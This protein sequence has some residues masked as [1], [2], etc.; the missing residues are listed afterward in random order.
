MTA[1]ASDDDPLAWTL[2]EAAEAVRRGAISSEALTGLCLERIDRLQPSLN[3][4][5]GV[6]G[7]RA[8][9]AARAADA[10]LASGAEIG[11]LHGVPLAHKDMFYRA[12]AVTTGGSR[13]WR[14]RVREHT[15]EVL[16]RLDT[17]GAIELG[18]LNLSEFA[19][20]PTGQNAHHGRACN[21]WDPALI[22]GGS[23]SGSAAAVAAG[24]AFGALGSDT[25]GSIRLP[26]AL[27]GVAGLKP[28][29][30]RVSVRD[31][32]PLA[33][34]MDCV[35][36]LARSVADLALI[37]AV[38]T[39]ASAE[40]PPDPAWAA[41]ALADRPSLQGVRIGIP[42]GLD[43]E[44]LEAEVAASLAKSR[45]DLER[46]GARLVTIAMPD[47]DTLCDLAGVVSMYEAAET[48]ADDFAA[49][50]EDYGPQ[51]RSRL[52]KA[53]EITP[54]D[55][56]RALKAQP[57]MLKIMATAF[58]ACDVIHMPALGVTPPRA[59]TVDVDGGPALVAMIASLTRFCR[60]ISYLGLPALA[61]PTGF[62]RAGLPLSMQWVAP[63]MA[64]AALFAVG[65]AF[66]RLR[67]PA[68]PA[69]RRMSG[70]N[71]PGADFA[72][73]AYVEP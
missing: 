42:Q 52:A 29:H 30:G 31:V 56:A 16:T 7:D 58:E 1:T 64:E 5:I 33:P 38:L 66:E 51:V 68:R 19:L 45:A 8:L 36:P 37:F 50:P 25:G 61:Q 69:I 13:I 22:T 41:A 26:A 57:E 71:S 54:E 20:G 21:P 18:R 73:T 27:C 10:R 12:G 70:P 6:D 14:D 46:L 55:Y 60:P 28:S 3:A 44:D 15:A 53:Q 72:A 2:V 34:S 24:M 4:F 35:G 67:G 65:G 59:E 49:R 47:I 43:R 63:P 11:P 48:H 17:A 23:S 9:A 62:T 40:T 39:D 32:M